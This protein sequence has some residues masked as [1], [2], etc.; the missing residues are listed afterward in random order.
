MG[1]RA[2]GHR[3]ARLVIGMLIGSML[4][5]QMMDIVVNVLLADG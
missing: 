5:I 1:I 4:K 2:L 3:R